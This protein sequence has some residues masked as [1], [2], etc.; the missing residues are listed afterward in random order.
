MGEVTPFERP[1]NWDKLR[2]DEAERVIRER[3]APENTGRVIITDH[4]FDRVGQRSI[5]RAE[6]MRILRE[7][8]CHSD[9]ELTEH[10]EWKVVIS[11]KV[12]GGREAGVVTV[13]LND[14]KRLVI[15]TVEWM[16][17]R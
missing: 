1:I 6:V 13:I 2:R 9:P 10:G 17:G 4:A 7:G 5:T 15:P 3:A 11:K 16:D 14:N 8:R 12:L